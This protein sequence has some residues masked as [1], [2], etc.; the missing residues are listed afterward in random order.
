MPRAQNPLPPVQAILASVDERGV[1]FKAGREPMLPMVPGEVP[2]H[3]AK[4]IC[5]EPDLQLAAGIPADDPIREEFATSQEQGRTARSHL[6]LVGEDAMSEKALAVIRKLSFRQHRP[7]AAVRKKRGRIFITT[8]GVVAVA[9]IRVSQDIE[10]AF[11]LRTLGSMRRNGHQLQT[12]DTPSHAQA[13]EGGRIRHVEEIVQGLAI[14]IAVQKIKVTSD[15][16]TRQEQRPG[17]SRAF[18]QVR[19]NEEAGPVF[20][21]LRQAGIADRG[22]EELDGATAVPTPLDKDLG[23]TVREKGEAVT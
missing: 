3:T 7:E 15:V 9:K 2:L 4:E 8:K 23:T 6:R 12:P 19:A 1:H 13:R 10:G 17:S 16:R 20:P 18:G 11:D 14:R 22:V 21:F 5:I